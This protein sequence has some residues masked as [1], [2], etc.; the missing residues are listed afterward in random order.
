MTEQNKKQQLTPEQIKHLMSMMQNQK[1]VSKSRKVLNKVLNS[2]SKTLGAAVTFVDRFVRFVVKK[3]EIDRNDVV[4]TARGP[5]LFGT[6]VILIFF[7]GGGLWS[8]FAPLDSAAVAIGQVIPS[9]KRKTIQHPHGGLVKEIFVALGD[10]VKSGDKL[11]ELEDVRFKADYETNLNNYRVF[12]ANEDRL[13]A[14]RDGLKEIKFEEFLLKDQDVREVSKLLDTERN[15]FN[16]NME[17]Y[18]K[19]VESLEQRKEQ[20]IKKLESLGARLKSAKKTS[21]FRKSTMESYRKLLAN[22]NIA[23]AKVLEAEAAFEAAIS[24]VFGTESE[25]ASTNQ[26]LVQDQAE[27]ASFKS[28]HMSRVVKE[29]NDTQRAKNEYKERYLQSKDS[30]ERVIVKSP[31]DG[32]VIEMYASTIGGVINPGH[33]IA[34]I[35]PTNDK[36]IIEARIPNR[37][38]DSVKVGLHAKIRFSAFKSRTS[39]MFNGV[40]TSLSP[41]VVQQQQQN[42]DPREGP[43][44]IAKIELDM[45]EFEKIAKLGNLS[46]KPG[47]QAEVQIVTGTRTLIQYL[48]SPVTDSMFKAFVEK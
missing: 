12:L 2:V 37:N 34:E 41:D 15:L 14:E 11:I 25:I 16:S 10:E 44:Y 36:L 32:T 40:V 47:M 30:F 6:Y 45:E 8:F 18:Y 21:E 43:V 26:A 4:Q 33:P 24:E 46:L 9:S 7:I 23:K 3:D 13:E 20:L 31:V 17:A 22:D 35:M 48:L 5:I 28:E 1:P 19:K 29:L 38:I 27:L 39:P 42:Q